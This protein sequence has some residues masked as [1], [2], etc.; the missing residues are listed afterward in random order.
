MVLDVIP[1]EN[2]KFVLSASLV[3]LPSM[4]FSCQHTICVH[5][6]PTPMGSI[7][8]LNTLIDIVV[9]PRSASRQSGTWLLAYYVLLLS[10]R[11]ECHDL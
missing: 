9:D 5:N 3:P 11:L 6:G 7:S 8:L 4:L 1:F 2:H 10:A